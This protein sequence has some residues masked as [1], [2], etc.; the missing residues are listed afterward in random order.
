MGLV[1]VWQEPALQG[2]PVDRQSLEQLRPET[3]SSV[4]ILAD[5]SEHWSVHPKYSSNIADADSRCLASLLLLR[6]IQ[7]SRMHFGNTRQSGGLS[8]V[9]LLLSRSPTVLKF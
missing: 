4:L 7:S 6:D 9:S 2:D 5:N 3:F 1:C 8:L